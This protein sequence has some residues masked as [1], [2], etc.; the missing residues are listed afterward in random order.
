MRHPQWVQV[1]RQDMDGAF[2]I[3]KRVILTTQVNF[4]GFIVV[5][6]ANLTICH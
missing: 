2:A 4:K 3:V 6:S 1:G 5:V